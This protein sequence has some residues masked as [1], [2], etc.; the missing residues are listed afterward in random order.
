MLIVNESLR[1]LNPYLI[2]QVAPALILYEYYNQ[3]GVKEKYFYKCSLSSCAQPEGGRLG[4]TGL[5]LSY[6]FTFIN[7]CILRK[8]NLIAIVNV[9]SS[10]RES[11]EQKP[12]QLNKN[13]ADQ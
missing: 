11:G 1:S 4:T 2:L 5:N 8:S 12:D 9:G 10:L 3:I 13:P 6:L 7:C